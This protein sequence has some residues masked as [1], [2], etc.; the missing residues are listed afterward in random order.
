MNGGEEVSGRLVITRG[1]CSVLL[2]LAVEILDEM[3]RLVQ[4]FVE[5]A[6]AFAIALGRDHRVFPGRTK[7]FDDALVSIKSFV[8]QQRI[9]LQLRQQRVG[10]LQIMRLTRGQEE[11]E[12]IAQGIDQGVDFGAQSAFAAPDRLVFAVFFL[13]PALCW[14][15]RTMVLSIMAYSLSASAAK[16]SNT[17]FHTSLLAQREKRV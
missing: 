2:E 4:L 5:G 12:R 8:C 16:V 6:W 10:P 13:A 14:C 17:L 3:A 15:A 1:N 11:G 9:G 7:R